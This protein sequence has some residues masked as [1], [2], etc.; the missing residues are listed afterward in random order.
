MCVGTDLRCRTTTACVQASDMVTGGCSTDLC[1][2]F[3]VQA[4]KVAAA[5]AREFIFHAGIA[6]APALQLI[7]KIGHNLQ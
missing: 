6:P 3:D 5:I 1:I 4:Y 7:K 2:D